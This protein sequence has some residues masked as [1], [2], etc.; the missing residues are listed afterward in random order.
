MTPSL[1]KAVRPGTLAAAATEHAG[2][3]RRL[4]VALR[5]HRVSENL[6]EPHEVQRV[7]GRLA[8]AQ[9]RAV[10][11]RGLV[12]TA[13]RMLT[14]RGVRGGML[15]VLVLAATGCSS[16]SKTATP[17]AAPTTAKTGIIVINPQFEGAGPFS[18]GL[19][20]VR[21][22]GKWGYIDQTG[23]YVI[24]PQFDDAESFSDGLAVVRI[25]DDTTG[26]WGYIDQTGRIVINPQFDEA[27]PFSDGLAQV[28]IGD[29]KT[30]KW[31]YIAR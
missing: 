13:V 1:S 18:D 31:G 23:R 10:A 2:L 21:I 9:H 29:V 22:G 17:A 20:A 28:R 14:M 15:A 4:D 7:P 25:G 12:P 19:A 6:G 30:G 26:K 24:N 27:Y 16:P 11:A 5:A 8:L 3:R